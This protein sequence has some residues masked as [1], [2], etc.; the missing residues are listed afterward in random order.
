[1]QRTRWFQQH[2]GQKKSIA[3]LR[4]LPGPLLTVLHGHAVVKSDRWNH[5]FQ[6][7]QVALEHPR[8][9]D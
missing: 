4:Q 9:R 6:N 5:R 3:V 8:S 1:M 7:S 2:N